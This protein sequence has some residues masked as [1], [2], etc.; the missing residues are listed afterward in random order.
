MPKL[1][2]NGGAKTYSGQW[3]TW[4]IW[5]EPERKALSDVLES[6]KW[7][8]GQRVK[9]FEESFS[10]FQDARFGVTTTSGSTA[11]EVA[12]RAL[13]IGPG[14][15]VIIPPYTFVA[16]AAS[17]IW[18]GA[19]PVFADIEPHTLCLDPHDVA[20]KITPRTRAILPV[21]LAGHP[22]D[23]DRLALLAR[24]HD[25]RV[26]E[27]AC[28]SWGSKWKGKG[29]GA[30]GDCGAFSFQMSK[31]ISSGE[32][33]I[34]L[35]DDSELA[36]V[37]RSLTNC[38]RMKGSPWYEHAMVG[39]NLRMTEFQAA[40][41]SAQLARAEE[42]LVTRRRNALIL[43]ERLERIAGIKVFSDDRR[44]T[45]RA[46]H[47]YCFQI[48]PSQL[49][50]SRARF[51]EALAAEGVPASGGYL[52]PLY[53]NPMFTPGD[54]DQPGARFRPQPGERLDYSGARCP[55]AE[56]VCETVCWFS[57][58]LL[59]AEEPAIHAAADAIE[60][61]CLNVNELRRVEIEVRAPASR[62]TVAA[63]RS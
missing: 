36:D 41:L 60:K 25:L 47:L 34:I 8:Y 58:V 37:C 43:N 21:H 33:G 18:V 15:E 14:D 3:P 7:W 62:A 2:I 63:P 52:M 59:L 12:L 44:V 48:D 27:D 13:G 38:G 28:H 26:I 57:H 39:S 19:T 46:Y 4:P 35:T 56:H 1:A 53:R 10:L 40:L 5:G 9:D 16:T 22:A 17:V 42:H 51:L 29:T 20:A 54:N 23:M 50:M 30:L 24:Q 6:G 31:N 32:G 49:G 11:L 61:V 55:V 45:C